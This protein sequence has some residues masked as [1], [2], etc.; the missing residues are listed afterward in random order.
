[1]FCCRL[2]VNLDKSEH[3]TLTA[4]TVFL[5][6]ERKASVIRVVANSAYRL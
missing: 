2:A 6:A 3:N 1:M 4:E 5:K